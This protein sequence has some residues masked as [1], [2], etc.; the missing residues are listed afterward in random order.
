MIEENMNDMKMVLFEDKNKNYIKY[1][2]KDLEK[3]RGCKFSIFKR[4]ESDN[5]ECLNEIISYFNS[6]NLKNRRF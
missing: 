6:E 1:N 2:D 4:N 3:Q 5:D